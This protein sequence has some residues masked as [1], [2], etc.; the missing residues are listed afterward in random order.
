MTPVKLGLDGNLISRRRIGKRH[1]T[2]LGRLREGWRHRRSSLVWQIDLCH[3]GHRG[4]GLRKAHLGE[5]MGLWRH[6]LLWMRLSRGHWLRWKRMLLQLLRRW[7]HLWAG[8]G[9]GKVR[10]L[11]RSGSVLIH[12][13]GSI[14]VV[15]GRIGH[16][17]EAILRGRRCGMVL[18]SDI[19]A[20]TA[21][22]VPRCWP[23]DH[24]GLRGAATR[25]E[26]DP[27]GNRRGG[28]RSMVDMLETRLVWHVRR[29]NGMRSTSRRE[30]FGGR[31]CLV[32]LLIIC[33]TLT[34]EVFGALMFVRRAEIL[35]SA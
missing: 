28:R 34:G 4:M 26:C 29:D 33:F 25:S 27:I 10:I 16:I 24:L 23:G 17:G 30:V 21:D 11:A 31:G 20:D 22:M 19:R 12:T 14:G 18:R 35:I 5:A 1:R 7:L 32:V 13:R 15:Y 2:G 9:M 3:L 8:L 6:M